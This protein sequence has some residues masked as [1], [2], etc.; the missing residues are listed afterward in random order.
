MQTNKKS[1]A[2]VVILWTCLSLALILFFAQHVTAA[3]TIKGRIDTV[4][5]KTVLTLWGSHFEMGYAHGYLLAD[6]ILNIIE[7]Y[8]LGNLYDPEHYWRTVILIK[9]YVRV[10][11]IFRREIAGMFQGIVDARGEQGVFSTTLNRDFKPVDLL[12]WNMVPDIFRL[13][14]TDA[15]FFQQPRFS[16]SIAGWGDG[17]ADGNV[18]IARDLD[19]GAPGDLLDQSSII[20]AYQPRLLLQHAWI[21]I[22]WPGFMG[23]LTGM[24]DEGVGAA[25]DL[26]NNPPELDDLLLPLAN[27]YLGIPRYYSPITFALRTGL[28]AYRCRK[29]RADPIGNLFAIVSSKHIAGSFDIH[30]FSP[31]LSDDLQPES[32]AAIIECNNRG[33]VLRTPD[34]NQQYEPKLFSKYFLA[35]TNHHRKLEQPVFS[36]RY[37]T[38][39]ERLNAI[40]FLTMD[41]AFAI[42]RAISQEVSPFNT[43][44]MVGFIP[45][46]REIWVA[47]GDGILR[48]PEIEPTLFQWNDIFKE[49]PWR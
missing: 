33:T 16:S 7:N 27:L 14:F 21:S 36:P 1:L 15:S 31:F 34:D 17:T 49:K 24:N 23:C 25:L 48:A 22:G 8:M 18:I 47:F 46:T 20:I 10:P 44:Q 26:G 30:V 5:G 19:F 38:Q 13:S 29:Y 11:R 42:E 35:V 3:K 12:A 43:V 9:R 28:E 39:V 45:E 6:E 41:K 4:K 32:P 40:D 2:A 37:E